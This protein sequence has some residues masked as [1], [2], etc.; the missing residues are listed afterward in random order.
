MSPLR[1][2]AGA[3]ALLLLGAC[4]T[5]PVQEATPPSRQGDVAYRIEPAGTEGVRQLK[6]GES[7][8]P[9]AFYDREQPM[10]EYPAGLLVEGLP[11]VS[12]LALLSID[13][14]GELASTQFPESAREG[15]AGCPGCL[16]E[17][18]RAIT[19]AVAGWTFGKLE[20]SGWIDGPDSNGDGEPDSVKRGVLGSRPY[21]L[22]LRFDFI[23]T[24]GRGVVRSRRSD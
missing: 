18:Q 3:V 1:G 7:A 10:P 16:A 5:R 19:D 23:Q 12:V 11:E 9:P 14:R 24:D 22:R 2:A 17:F 6:L 4:A 21:S 8:T 20:V 13:E 15:I